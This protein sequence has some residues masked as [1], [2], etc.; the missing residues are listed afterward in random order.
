ME[1]VRA[2][3]LVV[4]YHLDDV[5]LFDDKRVDLP[6]DDGVGVILSHGRRRIKGGHLLAD[7]GFPV[8]AG[9]WIA[10]GINAEAEVELDEMVVGGH[11][12]EV[13]ERLEVR[14]VGGTP[15]VDVVG[16]TREGG[17]FVHD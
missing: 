12:G 11:H 16:R 13:V 9:A 4:D 7:E 5:A 6:V 8:E 2:G 14:V 17:V 10:I 1:G 15:D 3:V